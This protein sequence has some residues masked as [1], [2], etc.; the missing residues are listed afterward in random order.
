MR[1][2]NAASWANK[3]I[4][5]LLEIELGILTAE[6]DLKSSSEQ[7]TVLKG[8]GVPEEDTLQSSDSKISV[9][10][11]AQD[12]SPQAD[13][14]NGRALPMQPFPDITGTKALR[15]VAPLYAYTAV[16]QGACVN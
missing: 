16:N 15:Y 13:V 14:K 1:S 12:S 3:F 8:L 10:Q 9:A 2:D 11:Y 5:T 6:R 4:Q 7:L